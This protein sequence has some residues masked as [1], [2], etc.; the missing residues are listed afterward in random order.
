MNTRTKSSKDM[1][2]ELSAD[3]QALTRSLRAKHKVCEEHEDV[4]ATSLIEIW[5]SSEAVRHF[6]V[7]RRAAAKT[8]TVKTADPAPSGS[9]GRGRETHVAL[10]NLPPPTPNR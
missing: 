9:G 10:H 5:L 4:A 2:A 7:Q 1:L 6:Q 8:I 3:N